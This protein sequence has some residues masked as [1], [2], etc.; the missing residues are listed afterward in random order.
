L[1]TTPDPV[2]GRFELY[3][4]PPGDYSVV[5]AGPGNATGVITGVPVLSDVSTVLNPSSVPIAVPTAG[6]L[7]TVSANVTAVPVP[8]AASL[9]VG[10]TLSGG[11]AIQVLARP[12]LGDG[13][14]V[15]LPLPAVPP[16]VAPFASMLVFAD[17]AA[18][19]VVGRYTVTARIE[20]LAPGLP[21]EKSAAIDIS[22]T[23]PDP[24]PVLLFTFP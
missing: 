13:T 9:R 1:T 3:P 16:R 19:A 21:A 23:V 12:A 24:L 14:A 7:R 4:V 20:P 22:A 18:P 2:T 10:Q 15:A 8:E 6:L 11:L 17:D 5:L